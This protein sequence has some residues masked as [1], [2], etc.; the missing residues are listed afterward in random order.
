MLS[1][2]IRLLSLVCVQYFVV[3]IVCVW[4][5]QIV[6][7]VRALCVLYTFRMHCMCMVCVL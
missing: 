5:M 4:S 6:I 1:C 3:I 7:M 2:V